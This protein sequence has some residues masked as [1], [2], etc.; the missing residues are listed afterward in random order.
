M[1]HLLLSSYQLREVQSGSNPMGI[2]VFLEILEKWNYD[3][4]PF[5]ALE[6]E[7]SSLDKEYAY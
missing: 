1:S 4:D 2:N 3:Q 5:M 7:V 6:Y